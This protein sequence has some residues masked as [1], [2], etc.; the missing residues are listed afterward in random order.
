MKTFYKHFKTILFTF[1]AI[2]SF[3]L[4]AWALPPVTWTG[5]GG[6]NYWSNASNWSSNSVPGSNRNVIIGNGNY[7]SVD[8][9]A[10][11]NSLTVEGSTL[12]LLSGCNLTIANDFALNDAPTVTVANGDTLSV[13]GDVTTSNYAEVYMNAGT[14]ITS[15]A[16]SFD[17]WY[18]F[19]NAT[20]VFNG[21]SGGQAIQGSYDMRNLIINNSDGVAMT[22]DL[23]V[24]GNIT[25]TGKLNGS[26]HWLY[27]SGN[28][29]I[30]E[31]DYDNA[32]DV[33]LLGTTPQ[34]IGN[35]SGTLSFYNLISCNDSG[36][37]FDGDI[38][39]D[40]ALAYGPA[41]LGYSG[42]SC[43]YLNG[44]DLTMNTSGSLGGNETDG[45]VICDSGHVIMD[46]GAA[47][48]TF[49]MGF[50][51]TQYTPVTMYGDDIH[52]YSVSLNKGATDGGFKSVSTDAL[53]ATLDV[54]SSQLEFYY[55]A[56]IEYKASDL[57]LSGFD[58]SNYDLFIRHSDPVSGMWTSLHS[59]L[60]ANDLGGG[61]YSVEIP[62]MP[63]NPND[64]NSFSFGNHNGALPVEMLSFSAR[65]D[66]G[67]N[68][69]EW[70]T[71]SEINND[72]FEIQRFDDSKKWNTIGEILGHGTTN[73]KQ[74]YSF[75][76]ASIQ[77]AGI[78][79]YRL[80]QVDYNGK[81]EYSE[82]RRV[83]NEK[84]INNIKV[85]PNPAND[86]LNISF[87]N[88]EEDKKISIFDMQGICVYSSENAIFN[89]A[90][91]IKSLGSGMYILK[92]YSTNQV[93][94]QVF[95]KQ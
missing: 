37:V 57:E 10:S 68:I 34:H 27:L 80:K 15:G 23:G 64:P 38:S 89:K 35:S 46:F 42:P 13:A 28:M 86:V 14:F 1:A 51:E 85:Y 79:Y 9:S 5:N 2:L 20:V 7:V 3:G 61:R 29:T 32:S 65:P 26:G 17:V 48:Q 45:Y 76:D 22:W 94:T 18:D 90:I 81:F 21:T 93:C 54:T 8:V 56:R 39:I 78:A 95:C 6:D 92:V 16:Y 84:Q 4:S 30:P 63:L 71:A 58:R 41:D 11:V 70:N 66:N 36:T 75:T 25:G 87:A 52:T 12:E 72:H 47:E 33:F 60:S 59:G 50:S 55:Y 49:P 83:S 74:F 24:Y 91:D 67:K 53:D 19:T 73:E 31:Y 77:N 88:D 40:G 43:I 62:S 69:L 44:H 82:I